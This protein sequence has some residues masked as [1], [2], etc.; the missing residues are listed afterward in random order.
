MGRGLQSGAMVKFG[1][2]KRQHGRVE[3]L[4]EVLER[5]IRECPHVSRIVPGRMGRKRG[6]SPARLKLKYATDATGN[7]AAEGRPAA[8]LKCIYTCG[9]SWQE[10]FL[11][12]E[13]ADAARCWLKETGL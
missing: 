7:L 8:G 4:D 13:N 10:V 5:I 11:I 2:I 6:R 1:K 3:G 12:C 9:G